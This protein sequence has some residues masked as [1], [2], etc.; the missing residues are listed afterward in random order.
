M[1]DRQPR[2][3]RDLFVIGV[4]SLIL[5]S[6]LTYATVFGEV[7]TGEANFDFI[8][9]EGM[10]LMD[11]VGPWFGVLFWLTGVFVLFSTNLG[12]LDY[13]CRATADILK[14]DFLRTSTFWS[15]SKLYFLVVWT[16][17]A[18]GSIILLAGVDQPFL[19]LV[20]SSSISGGV[21][22]IYTILL[23]II[24]RR[25]L[26]RQIRLGGFR[27]VA[28]YGAL[29]FFGFFVAWLVVAFAG[30]LFAGG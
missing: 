30:A 22:V 21:M 18:V 4:L 29:A 17:I 5:L 15:E 13:V 23:I 24:N 26:P 27:L 19:L 2:A 20:I 1:E 16:M 9:L 6:G 3:I 25:F 11:A 28:M 10:A 14:V 8:R 12:I 7:E